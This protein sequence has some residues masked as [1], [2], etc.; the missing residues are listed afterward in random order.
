MM[1][2]VAIWETIDYAHKVEAIHYSTIM[3]CDHNYKHMTMNT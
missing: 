3:T 2:I 1:A